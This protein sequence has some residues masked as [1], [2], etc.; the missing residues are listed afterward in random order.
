MNEYGGLGIVIEENE[1]KTYAPDLNLKRPNILSNSNSMNSMMTQST[2]VASS[3]M[4]IEENE[5]TEDQQ[6]PV[7]EYAEQQDTNRNESTT[8]ISR[9]SI[10]TESL[11]PP[12]PDAIEDLTTSEK[13]PA[14]TTTTTTTF[15]DSHSTHSNDSILSNK[16]AEYKKTVYLTNN[17]PAGN[18]SNYALD[19]LNQNSSLQLFPRLSK[20]TLDESLSLNGSLS[21]T[22]T[23]KSSPQSTNGTTITAND[24]TNSNNSTSSHSPLKKLRS[25]KNGIR[26]LSLSNMNGSSNNSSIAS[27]PSTPK[28]PN[29]SYTQPEPIHIHTHSH[30][31]SNSTSS[32]SSYSSNSVR[33]KRSRVP[34]QSSPPIMSPV[35]T[36]SENLSST[37]RTLNNMEQNYFDSKF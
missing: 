1:E 37:K 22:N 21:A 31:H 28:I 7:V 29:L 25:I 12:L 4:I 26:K 23:N 14:S 36:L 10:E 20:S 33:S 34:S 6:I 8:T 9:A 5:H 13:P 15:E 27:S 35:I 2:S 11:L 19:S 18:F 3:P 24:S 30:S 17:N 32:N 16:D